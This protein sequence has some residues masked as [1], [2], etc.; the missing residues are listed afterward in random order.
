M[1][2]QVTIE[3]LLPHMTLS[4]YNNQRNFTETREMKKKKSYIH[5]NSKQSHMF[6]CTTKVTKAVTVSIN[7][8]KMSTISREERKKNDACV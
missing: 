4:K 7:I 1:R 5:K 2:G 8:I 3:Q 6:I